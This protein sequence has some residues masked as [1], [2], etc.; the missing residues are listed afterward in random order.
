M[1]KIILQR[2]PE[3]DLWVGCIAGKSE[4]VTYRDTSAECVRVLLKYLNVADAEYFN[5]I[6]LLEGNSG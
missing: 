4:T 1:D 5:V 3:Y 2:D 6:S